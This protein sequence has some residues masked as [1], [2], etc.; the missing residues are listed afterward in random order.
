MRT[1]SSITITAIL[2]VAATPLQAKER[3]PLSPS[4]PWNIHYANDS[5]RLVRTFGKGDEAVSLVMDRFEPGD[6]FKL[7]FVGKSL[8]RRNDGSM[9]DG[10]LRFGPDADDQDVA[11]FTGTHGDLPALIVHGP[12]RIIPLTK[13]QEAAQEAAWDAGREYILPPIS[14][15]RKAQVRWLNLSR[16]LT[17]DVV[18]E[19]GSLA[20]PL[21]ALE[22]CSWDLLKVWGLDPEQQK[23][24]TRQVR[25]VRGMAGEISPDDYPED[26]LRKGG[27]GTV[28]VRLLVDAQGKVTSCKNLVLTKD[29]DFGEVVCQKFRSIKFDPALD[30]AG[31]PAPSYYIQSV[32]FRME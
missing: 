26:M 9:L 10:R 18:L 31:R 27:Q 24:L 5:C 29:T 23:T 22:T 2:A 6:Q 21:A 20:K 25:P 15:E 32:T 7:I 12:L 8:K 13:D 14:E 4:T 28:T 17:K 11:V 16:I 1:S 19:T 3:T 30:S